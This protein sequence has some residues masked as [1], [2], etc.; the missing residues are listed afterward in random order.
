MGNYCVTVIFCVGPSLSVVARQLD[1]PLGKWK[2]FSKFN[3]VNE[4]SN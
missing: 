4:N 1:F 2:M 3:Y